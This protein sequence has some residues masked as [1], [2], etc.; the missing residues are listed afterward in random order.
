MEMHQI[1]YFLAL[2]EE[3]NFTRAAERCN[4]AQPSLTRAIRLLE[5]EFGGALV[6]RE[7]ANTHL[8]ELGRVMRPYL[9]DVYAQAQLA[10]SEARKLKTAKRLTLRLGVMC[11]IAPTPLLALMDALG[12]RHPDLDLE[13]ID[14]T[15]RDLEER[16][17][18]DE[19]EVAIYCRPDHP[20]D[21]LHYHKL[22]RERMMIVLAPTHPLAGHNP[23]RFQD[24]HN[25]RYLNRINCEFNE[26]LAW[27][28]CGVTWPAV[29]RSE[30]DDWILAMCAA[31]K[32]FGFLPE[33]CIN[34]PGSC[35]PPDRR[36]RVLARGQY[37]H[38][39][40]TAAFAGGRR[41]RARSHPQQLGRR[42]GCSAAERIARALRIHSQSAFP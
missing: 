25:Q 29:F 33:F 2:C 4:V 6:N 8:T 10:R 9:A 27:E 19:L 24:L 15:A 40:R 39:A 5:E 23:I 22:F 31:G 38:R 7:R 21:R 20:D 26:G 42:E 14:A 41:T 16:L 3:L 18:R 11:T 35:F 34:H 30:R 37:R 12:R 28:Q 36:P 17:K 13:V 1:R 32:G